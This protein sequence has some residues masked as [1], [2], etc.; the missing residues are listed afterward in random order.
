MFMSNNGILSLQQMAAR[1]AIQDIFEASVVYFHSASDD[2]ASMLDFA[3]RI[4][5]Y[6]MLV[7]RKGQLGV[8]VGDNDITLR[9]GDLLIL[10][11]FQ[12]VITRSLG[13]QTEVE[14]L[15]IETNFYAGLRSLDR[16][17]DVMM[18][19]VITNSNLVFHLGHT[20]TANLISLLR[21]IQKAIR[22]PHLYT[23]E[24]LKSF[25]HICLLFITELPYDNSVLTHDFKH[26][27][28]IFKIFIHLAHSNFRKE[29][30]IRFYADKLNMT[31][32]Y[33][34][35]T[36]REISGT[37]VY[38]HLALLTYHEACMLLRTSDLTVGEI[39]DMLHFN[40]TSAFTNFFKGKAGVSPLSYRNKKE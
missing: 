5:F 31:T 33:L 40:D 38:D 21:Q 24:I 39:A 20:Q 6:E 1:Y 25:V 28:N 17:T 13:T 27:E 37:T 26:K 30:Q 8:R 19:T 4:S 16:E 29:R 35:R 32:T 15:L 7:V 12:P 3:G 23:L 11:P 10:T 36:V 14:G 34:S 2:H 22:Q 18:P 9:A